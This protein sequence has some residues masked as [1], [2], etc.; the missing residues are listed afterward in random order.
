MKFSVETLH[1]LFVA[2]KNP[3]LLDFE[4]DLSRILTIARLLKK[5]KTSGETNVKLLVNYMVISYNVFG[6]AFTIIMRDNINEDILPYLNSLLEYMGRE[7]V[8]PKS[9]DFLSYLHENI[10]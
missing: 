2:Y 10:K 1:A 6:A 5:Y 9:G 7:N 3:L 4:E 8:E